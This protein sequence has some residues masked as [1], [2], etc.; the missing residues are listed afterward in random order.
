MK[1]HKKQKQPRKQNK[2]K[3]HSQV[4]GINGLLKRF[5]SLVFDGEFEE[6]LFFSD[7]WLCDKQIDDVIYYL[8]LADCYMEFEDYDKALETIQKADELFPVEVNVQLKLANIYFYLSQNKKAEEYIT[9]ALLFADKEDSKLLSDLFFDI[10][11]IYSE[12][13]MFEKSFEMA[14]RALKENKDNEDAA[15]YLEDSR[16]SYGMVKL[17]NKTF[18]DFGY[19]NKVQYEKFVVYKGGKDAE[20]EEEKMPVSIVISAGWIKLFSE[21]YQ[22]IKILDTVE[23]A[24]IFEN[25]EI[26][27]S[28]V[29]VVM[30][31]WDE[32]KRL[33]N[34]YF[35][36]F[37]VYGAAFP[38]LTTFQISSFPLV[39]EFLV[40]AGID[41]LR[42]D[43]LISGEPISD[44]EK[45]IIQKSFEILEFVIQ[46][47][48]DA[49][50]DN[51]DNDFDEADEY[52]AKANTI[53][54][55]FISK[56]MAELVVDNMIYEFGEM[57]GIISAFDSKNDPEFDKE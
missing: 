44:S 37:A 12:F 40:E 28:K 16:N 2:Q 41:K 35:G 11:M 30:N 6:A 48:N 52:L 29:S 47:F 42:M 50:Y 53:A 5:H 3:K 45:R 34:F 20:L 33:E 39:G 55:E 1:K 19:F 7:E 15:E 57:A 27:F 56:A 22:K 25:Y 46:S 36:N 32:L 14:E 51:D 17:L 10:A 21:N 13:H 38:F 49:D 18:D 54:A 23:K 31:E 26:D 9:S 24:K 43:E 8:D 4:I